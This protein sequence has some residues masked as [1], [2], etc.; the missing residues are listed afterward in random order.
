MD[1]VMTCVEPEDPSGVT[2]GQEE[3][4]MTPEHITALATLVSAIAGLVWA[5]RRKS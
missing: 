3:L 2:P 4:S 1:A 5:A